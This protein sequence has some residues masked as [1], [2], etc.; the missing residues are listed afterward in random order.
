MTKFYQ[1]CVCVCVFVTHSR[2]QGERDSLSRRLAALGPVTTTNP[3]SAS[4]R[5]YAPMNNYCLVF[6]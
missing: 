3:S 6:Y 5:S 2:A 4:V 1:L